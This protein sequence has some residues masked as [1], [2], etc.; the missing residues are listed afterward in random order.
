M[1]EN[2]I[3]QKGRADR[4]FLLGAEET[5]MRKVV[6]V[7]HSLQDLGGRDEAGGHCSS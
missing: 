6:R 7:L 3:G 1:W 2:G 4:P 5:A